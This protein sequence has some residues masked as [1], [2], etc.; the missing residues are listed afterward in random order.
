MRKL[1]RSI[2]KANMKT[3]GFERLFKKFSWEDKKKKQSNF[4]RHWKEWVVPTGNNANLLAKA[5]T[6]AQRLAR[7]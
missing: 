4:A 3:V 7:A 1:K 2:A 6:K 5:C